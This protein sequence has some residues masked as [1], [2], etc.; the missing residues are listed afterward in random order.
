MINNSPNMSKT[1]IFNELPLPENADVT[2]YGSKVIYKAIFICVKL[3][4]DIRLNLVMISEGKKI[5]TKHKTFNK[6]KSNNGNLVIKDSDNINL[7]KK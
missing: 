3:L 5:Q 4:L 6:K 7:E 2:T 1:Q